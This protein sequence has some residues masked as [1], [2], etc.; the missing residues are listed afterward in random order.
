[1]YMKLRATWS[2]IQAENYQKKV[3]AFRKVKGF[4]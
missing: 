2:Y 1:M 4:A 3:K